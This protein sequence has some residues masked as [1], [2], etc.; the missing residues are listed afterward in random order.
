MSNVTPLTPPGP[1]ARVKRDQWGRY[2][3]PHPETGKEQSWTRATT[4][5]GTLADRYALE[6]WDQRNVILG[7]GARR[8]LYAQAAAAT[9]DDVD[10]LNGIAVQA[11]E[12]AKAKAGANMGS[13][14]HRLTERVDASEITPAEIDD[15]TLRGD[16]DA[17]AAAMQA[18][19]VVVVP[20]W[21]ERILLVPAIDVA[22]TCDRLCNGMWDLPRIGD[23][24]T[25]KDVV[26]WGMAE[27]PLQLS[28]YAH[29]SHWY[30]P[31]TE[32]LHEMPQ[33]DQDKA[34]VMHLPAG[35]GECTLYEVDITAGWEAVQLAV[36]VRDWRKRKG[37]AQ[38][39]P[40]MGLKPEPPLAGPVTV[41]P[42]ALEPTN[43]LSSARA[44]WIRARVER[45]VELGHGQALA[46]IWSTRTDVPTFKQ[47]GPRDDNDIDVIAGMCDLAEMQHDVSFG[48]S[49]PAVPPATTTKKERATA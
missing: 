24:K 28:I 21:L 10:T 9:P 25:G 18:A 23:V 38:Q 44:N 43:S 29:A 42:P 3:L 33:V 26:R 6:K 1:A 22:G 15:P 47:G 35:K 4:L 48:P 11:R 27:I 31:A 46:N 8:D 45:L 36:A 41:T 14:L 40:V 7:I 20:G 39:I 30:D 32:Q 13:A 2:L 12:A 37:L 34:I 5:A 16:I 19:G 49:D 17:Y